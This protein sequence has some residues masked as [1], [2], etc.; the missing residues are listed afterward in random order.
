L[1]AKLTNS[2]VVFSAALFAAV[3][4][5]TPATA[6]N[7]VIQ[8]DVAT[9][10]ATPDAK[11]ELDGTVKFYFGTTAH[12]AV[13]KHLGEGVTNKKANGFGKSSTKG[14]DR[15]FLSALIQLQARAKELGSNAVINI[16]SYFKKN[17]TV[18]NTTVECHSGL[19]MDGVA[20]KGEFV[21]IG[22]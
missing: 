9:V 19:L 3:L 1:R 10:M 2:T 21:K 7:D 11:A 8:L 20:L 5:W 12:P 17:E 4:A 6:A 18:S 14:C 13:V 16:H 15:A 22:N